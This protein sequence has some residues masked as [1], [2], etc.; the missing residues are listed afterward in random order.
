M[1]GM[2]RAFR[3]IPAL[4]WPL[5]PVL[6]IGLGLAFFYAGVQKYLAPYEFAEAILA[7]QLLP[8]TLVGLTAAIFP[9]LELAVGGFLVLGYLVEARC[10]CRTSGLPS[11]AEVSR[12]ALY[13]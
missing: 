1:P 10:L 6:R 2:K 5:R 7:Y 11:R 4:E 13:C 12:A 9:R 8:Q 3:L